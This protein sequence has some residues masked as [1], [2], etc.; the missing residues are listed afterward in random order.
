MLNKIIYIMEKIDF[1]QK[2][3]KILFNVKMIIYILYF[4]K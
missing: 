2:Y 1:V 4:F 3:I